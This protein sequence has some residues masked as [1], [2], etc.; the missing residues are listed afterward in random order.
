MVE[1]KKQKMPTRYSEEEL[2]L[3]KNT[4]AKKDE[5]LIALRKML[6]QI[7]LTEKEEKFKEIFNEQVVKAIRKVMFPS[8]EGDEKLYMVIDLWSKTV[9]NIDEL[10]NRKS[11]ISIDARARF[12]EYLD[13]QLNII[14]GYIPANIIS[15]ESFDYNKE[16][17]D[18]EKQKKL[19]IRQLLLTHIE[20]HL[21]QIRILANQDGDET[22][23]ETLKRL[24]LD[25]SK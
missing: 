8:I 1:E 9:I 5:L 11:I 18:E 21:M 6:L 13:Q 3:L 4:F 12:L 15:F 20:N 17:E 7:D 14:V 23:E 22:P 10:E 2:S 16:D 25:S 24:N 19:I